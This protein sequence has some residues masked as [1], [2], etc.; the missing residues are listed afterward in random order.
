M[1]LSKLENG[2]RQLLSHARR[3][4]AHQLQ[5]WLQTA[6]RRVSITFASDMELLSFYRPKTRLLGKCIF[7]RLMR[8]PCR[9]SGRE[10]AFIRQFPRTPELSPHNPRPQQQRLQSLGGDDVKLWIY[11]LLLYTGR[12]SHRQK[13]AAGAV[14]DFPPLHHQAS[15]QIAE[16][17][18]PLLAAIPLPNSSFPSWKIPHLVTRPQVYKNGGPQRPPNRHC[19][20]R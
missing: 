10:L 11:F 3:R 15:S 18:S 6:C 14:A 2:N 7:P 9:H 20:R 13:P 1:F 5:R 17:C 8:F 16:V 12:I 19:R 4:G